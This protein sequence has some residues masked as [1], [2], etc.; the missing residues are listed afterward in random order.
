MRIRYSVLVSLA[1]LGCILAQESNS[2]P[3]QTQPGKTKPDYFTLPQFRPLRPFVQQ[4]G[5][6]PQEAP[7]AKSRFDFKFPLSDSYA[8]PCHRAD[9]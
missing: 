9:L 2:A 6:A 3:Q 7:L 1:T 8:V 4:D 5:R